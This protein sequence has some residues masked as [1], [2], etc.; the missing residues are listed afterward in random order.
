MDGFEA[1]LVVDRGVFQHDEHD[2]GQGDAAQKPKIADHWD[3]SLNVV[4]RSA[5]R[6]FSFVSKKTRLEKPGYSFT[7]PL[8]RMHS[9]ND[10]Y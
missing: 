9:S 4:R 6:T 2:N 8:S 3:S 7:Q 5:K 10:L 1:A